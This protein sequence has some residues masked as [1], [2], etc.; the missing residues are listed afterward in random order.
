MNPTHTFH[1]T[2]VESPVARIALALEGDTLRALRFDGMQSTVASL[3]ARQFGADAVIV[4]SDDA[5]PAVDALRAYFAGDLGALDAIAVDPAGT[6]FQQR[7][8][9]ELRRIPV[10]QTASYAQIAS[11]IGAPTA[12][13]AVARANATNPIGVVIPCH[14]VIGA[15]GA[16]RG[17][18][19]GVDRKRWLLAHEG[20]IAF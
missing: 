12:F 9:R 8:W 18:G 17:Y 6:P 11:R 19:G 10:G 1:V 4:E 7:V 14:R 16:L 2:S 15:D 20:A 3:L 5:H 13:R